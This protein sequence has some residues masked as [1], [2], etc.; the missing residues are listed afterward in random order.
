VLPFATSSFLWKLNGIGVG[1]RIRVGDGRDDDNDVEGEY[2]SFH[3]FSISSSVTP[4]SLAFF[5]V[6]YPIDFR[7]SFCSA[8]VKGVV[9]SVFEP[10]ETREKKNGT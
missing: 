4:S 5:M 8:A 2:N 1:G 9:R 7:T 3:F 6:R 10:L